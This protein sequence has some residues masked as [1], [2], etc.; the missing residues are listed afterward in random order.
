MDLAHE[1]DPLLR[2]SMELVLLT[3][4][5]IAATVAVRTLAR[6]TAIRRAAG[7]IAIPD[8]SNP[9][10]DENQGRLAR[11]LHRAGYRA[12]AASAQFVLATAGCST[13]GLLIGLALDRLGVIGEMVTALAAVPGSVGEVLG[14]IALASPYILFTI[15]AAAPWMV[16]RAAR[17]ERIESI[18][19]DLPSTLELLATLAE[20]GLGLDSAIARVTE[21]RS[22]P[23]PLSQEFEIYQRDL[24]GGINRFQALRLLATRAEVTSVSIFVS[25]L[26]QAEQVGSSLA[27][28]LRSQADDLRDRRKLQ[29]LVRA[30]ALP[31][32]LTFPL[33][34]C[35]L[36]GIFFVVLGPVLYQLVD[37]V[38]AIINRK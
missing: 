14:Y 17:R 16:V 20:A 8:H 3:L 34:A 22:K 12:P 18:E 23:R 28:T 25:A 13:A 38:D 5:M 6:R 32:K 1:P 29:A 24:L 37:V 21:S 2:L 4:L 36:P 27:E 26:V 10:N 33:I 35:F 7:L 9:I 11:W 31:V 30:Q 15:A 19:Q